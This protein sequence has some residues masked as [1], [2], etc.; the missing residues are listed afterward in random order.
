[1]KL[2]AA[3]RETVQ[4]IYAVFGGQEWTAAEIKAAGIPLTSPHLQAFRGRG[5]IENRSPD[6]D[7]KFRKRCV[8]SARGNTK[9]RLTGD[10]IDR[11]QTWKPAEASS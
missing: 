8:P 5:I 7:G 10:V 3:T 11:M 4:Q 2:C 6:K 1:M 9:W